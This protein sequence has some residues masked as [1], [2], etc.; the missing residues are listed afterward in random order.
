[1]KLTVILGA[2]EEAS[3]DIAL[4]DNSF[5]RKWVDEL[6]WCLDN[7]EFNQS[8]A[9]SSFSTLAESA[10]ILTQSCITIN[11]YLKNFI[12]VRKDIVDQ[13]QDYFN[14]LHN[15]FELLSGN[16][17]KPTKL[18][19][20][21]NREL[22][23]AIRNLNLFVHRI[24]TKRQSIPRFYISFNK[25]Q[26]RRWPF[27][28]TDYDFFEFKFPAGTLFLHY[29]EVGK[30]F[31]DLYSDNLPLDYAGYK[32]LHYYS[33]EALIAEQDYDLFKDEKFKEWLIKQGI[34]PYDKTLGHGKIPLGKVDNL[35]MAVDN[36][37]KFKYINKI[38][39][40]EINHG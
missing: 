12:E 9:F 16:F 22:K 40:K 6:S 38:L 20:M 1:M 34:D 2:N 39:I 13:P 18:F 29:A 30:D 28:H 36:I 19:T 8:E 5:T 27:E 32:N 37:A 24:E 33:G 26:Y 31:I 14:Y 3:F 11:K 35:A 4:Y 21:A 10:E 23:N 15:K 7:C 17:G 25:D